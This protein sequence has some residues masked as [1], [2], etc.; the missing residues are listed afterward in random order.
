MLRFVEVGL[1]FCPFALYGLWVFLGRSFSARFMWI[2][3]TGLTVLAV[4]TIWYGLARSLPP[5]DRYVPAHI[6]NGHIVQGRGVAP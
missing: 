6:E 5:Q 3:V 2:A 4:A 1:F